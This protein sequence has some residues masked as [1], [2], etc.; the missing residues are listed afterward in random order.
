MCGCVLFCEYK[1]LLIYLVPPHPF[2]KFGSATENNNDPQSFAEM[3]FSYISF[4]INITN[5]SGKSY[6]N[7]F[8]DT[9][10]HTISNVPLQTEHFYS[11]SIVSHTWK[12]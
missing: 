12:L 10:N 9:S 4:V 3:T 6:I 11:F 8:N 7:S 1:I 2:K 5:I